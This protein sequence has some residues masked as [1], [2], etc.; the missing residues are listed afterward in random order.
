MWLT[1]RTGASEPSRTRTIWPRLISRAGGQVVSAADA[2]LAVQE[3]AFLSASR[4]CSEFARNVLAFGD[5]ADLNPG[6]DSSVA[7][8]PENSCQ[9]Y[10]RLE[11][12]FQSPIKQ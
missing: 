12:I 10:S 6:W 3:T 5:I 4:I 1:Q 7:V 9:S 11:V 2:H 8:S